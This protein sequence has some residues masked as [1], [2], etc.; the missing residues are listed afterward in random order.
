MPVSISITKIAAKIVTIGKTTKE[1]FS[2]L[3]KRSK[4]GCIIFLI[5]PKTINGAGEKFRGY[6][7]IPD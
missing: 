7:P 4:K 1:N 6:H 3:R 2:L 5:F